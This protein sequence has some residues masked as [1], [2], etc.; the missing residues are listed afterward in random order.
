MGYEN[1]LLERDGS[2]A[3]V[4][5]NRPERRNA[6]SLAMLTELTSCFRNIGGD[7]EVRVAIG[8]GML[9]RRHEP[10]D[11]LGGRVGL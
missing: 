10:L 1:I 5:L 2:T 11:A 4:T 3:I 8:E 6:L 7:P 9:S